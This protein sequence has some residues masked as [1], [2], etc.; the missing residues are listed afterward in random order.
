MRKTR[1]N[2]TTDNSLLTERRERTKKETLSSSE[3]D[4]GDIECRCEESTRMTLKEIIMS[5]LTD[6]M[7]WRRKK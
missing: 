1:K 6:L 4:L 2:T 5:I 3:T 7:F